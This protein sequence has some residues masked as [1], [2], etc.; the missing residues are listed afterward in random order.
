ML[1]LKIR[2]KVKDDVLVQ[3]IDIIGKKE[4]C[5]NLKELSSD[6]AKVLSVIFS[7]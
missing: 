5:S 6:K 2:K 3:K 7:W 1:S 4:K